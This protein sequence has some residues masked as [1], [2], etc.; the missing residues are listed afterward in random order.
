VVV[1]LFGCSLNWHFVEKGHKLLT[2]NHHNSVSFDGSK[3]YQGNTGTFRSL[4]VTEIR[5]TMCD[6]LAVPVHSTKLILR[7]LF[8]VWF[9]TIGC[10]TDIRPDDDGGAP[11]AYMSK[12]SSLVFINFR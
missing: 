11:G 1:N 7:T 3:S 2:R 4:L 6:I 9:S 10:K 8:D 5:S 12:D